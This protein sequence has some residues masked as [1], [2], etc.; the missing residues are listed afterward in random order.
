MDSRVWPIYLREVL[1]GVIAEPSVVL[2]DNFDAHVSEEGYR[3]V[4]EELGSHLCTIPPNAALV[5]Q[6]LDFGIMAPF[7]K[8]LRRLW[9]EETFVEGDDDEDDEGSPTARIKR[10]VMIK[11]AIKA[12]DLITAEEIRAS[13]AKAIP[14]QNT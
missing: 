9:L 13:F 12:W 3:V 1:G 2:V 7:K 11:R 6:S 8:Y 14:V 10:F 5:C 4:N